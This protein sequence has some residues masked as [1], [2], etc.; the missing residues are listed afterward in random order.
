MTDAI[1]V[2]LRR[3]LKRLKLS[4]MLETLPERLVLARQRKTPHQDFLELVLSDEV[5]RREPLLVPEGATDC[6]R[7][8][9][10]ESVGVNCVRD[11]VDTGRGHVVEIADGTRDER[12][13]R[14]S[15]VTEP[16]QDERTDA[17]P[18]GAHCA[19]G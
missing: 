3:T 11:D 17:F 10:V 14:D 9:D 15:L 7:V 6:A 19:R 16:V 18:G 12:R 8:V 5:S 13:D 4:P 1:S 2:D